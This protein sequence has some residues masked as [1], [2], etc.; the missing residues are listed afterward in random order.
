[1]T[2]PRIIERPR[3]PVVTLLSGGQDSTTADV[4]LLTPLLPRSK[5]ATVELARELGPACWA[6]LADS[7]TC[8]RPQ[9]PS[10]A[11]LAIR[12]CGVCPA[13][14]LRAQGFAEAGELDPAL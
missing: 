6:A 14:V 3:V 5:R 13:C 2:T 12:P 9:P 8:Y 1:M 10:E 7:W 11:D 4:M